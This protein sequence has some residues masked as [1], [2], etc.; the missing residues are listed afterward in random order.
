MVEVDGL[1]VNL[2]FTNPLYISNFVDD[3][4]SIIVEVHPKIYELSYSPEEYRY[5][6][7]SALSQKVKVEVKQIDESRADAID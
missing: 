6:L 1:R 5:A 4:D 3:L 7:K 2:N